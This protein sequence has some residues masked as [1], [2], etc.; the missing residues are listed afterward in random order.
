MVR[1]CCGRGAALEC[2][3][4]YSAPYSLPIRSSMGGPAVKPKP[5]AEAGA[6]GAMAAI[7][8]TNVIVMDFMGLSPRAS[9]QF[10][11]PG[12]VASAVQFS[13]MVSQVGPTPALAAYQRI[14][15]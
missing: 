5:A 2:R 14:R 11:E 12:I 4:W 10:A 15:P 9:L 3:G 8:R 13:F 7:A 6:V 1:Q